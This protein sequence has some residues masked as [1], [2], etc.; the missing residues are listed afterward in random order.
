MRTRRLIIIMG[1]LVWILGAPVAI[2]Y[3]GCVGMGRTCDAPCLLTSDALLLVADLVAFQAVEPLQSER[4][5]YLPTPGRKVP[6]PPPRSTLF[7]A[8]FPAIS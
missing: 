6:T 4:S 1:L 3:G 8:L 2:A 5:F 7:S